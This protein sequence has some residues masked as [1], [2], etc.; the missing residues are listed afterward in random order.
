M[1]IDYD[2][3]QHLSLREPKTLLQR[4]AKLVEESGE[5]AQEILIEQNASGF[6]HKQRGD[7]GIAGEAVDVLLVCLSIFFKNGGDMQELEH[8]VTR[9]CHKWQTWQK[10]DDNE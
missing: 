9:K 4:F 10:V 7:D 5:L 1:A 3:I 2:L 6:Q 8:H